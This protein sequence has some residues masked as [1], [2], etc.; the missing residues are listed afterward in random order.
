MPRL[1][2][3]IRATIS[4][5]PSSTFVPG[6]E[7]DPSFLFY[8][9]RDLS[10]GQNT[11]NTGIIE[12]KVGSFSIVFDAKDIHNVVDLSQA[13]I[14]ITMFCRLEI[15]DDDLGKSCGYKRTQAIG[16]AI[17]Y[18][19]DLMNAY[20][21]KH[22][23]RVD[24]LDKSPAD[25]SDTLLRA[26]LDLQVEKIDFSSD[27]TLK[28][29][30]SRGVEIQNAWR[31]VTLE[32]DFV[33]F[34]KTHTPV[35][36]SIA[37]MHVPTWKGHSISIPAYMWI[38]HRIHRTRLA[39]F[40]KYFQRC[41]EISLSLHDW[42]LEE[43]LDVSKRQSYETASS[44]DPLFNLCIKIVATAGCVTSYATDYVS[45]LCNGKDV[46]RFKETF[47]SY[48]A[49]D[50]EDVAFAIYLC[51]MT[52]L[53]PEMPRTNESW[54]AMCIYIV[55]LYVV[56][57]MTGSA[58]TPSMERTT[59]KNIN[60][61]ICHIFS[62]MMPRKEF[63]KRLEIPGDEKNSIAEGMAIEIPFYPWQDRLPPL[64]LEG[65]NMNCQLMEP[66]W[67]YA[68]DKSIGNHLRTIEDYREFVETKYN[69]LSKLVIE[70]QQCNYTCKGSL[71][72]KNFSAFYHRVNNVWVDLT[73]FGSNKTDFSVGYGHSE[74]HTYGVSACSWSNPSMDG[75]YIFE[76]IRELS[77]EDWDICMHTIDKE[78]PI[79]VP[80]VAEK[81]LSTHPPGF[82]AELCEKYPPKNR[83]MTPSPWKHTYVSYRLNRW[84]KLLITDMETTLRNILS[85]GYYDGIKVLE[86][87][88]T[89]DGELYLG[90]IRLFVPEKIFDPL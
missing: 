24:V 27:V 42:K 32:Q 8:L 9:S 52:L 55:R 41:L 38:Y 60:K 49:G 3:E 80:Q 43:F 81:T 61:L 36:S 34:Y 89:S 56:T 51:L 65:T 48:F 82:L 59:G 23:Q 54:L 18:L 66:W 35:V 20:N 57:M 29:T 16:E 90:E 46:E 17:V 11:Q 33:R 86:Y 31:M 72:E 12:K 63:C 21:T 78:P 50:C 7:S 40:C 47:G 30:R 85:E 53:D 6:Y 83:R 45:D 19:E 84:E 68:S 28:D 4:N 79:E 15:K 73:R 1:S 13:C 75:D 37:P 44:Y 2:L 76:N 26:S 14:G 5:D 64:I 77:P 88:M 62:G 10:D 39:A 58:T 87:P 69:N 22:I 71:T 25:E 70:L 67:T 74:A